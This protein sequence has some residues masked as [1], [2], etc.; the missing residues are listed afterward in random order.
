MEVGSSIIK[1]ARNASAKY[2]ADKL[3]KSSILIDVGVA[4]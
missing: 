3:R 4:F 1:V 2:I